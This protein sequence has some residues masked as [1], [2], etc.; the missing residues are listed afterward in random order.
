MSRQA[1][2]QDF[3]IPE[4]RGRDPQDYEVREDG[5]VARKDRWE[6]GIRRI[7]SALGDQRRE[8]EVEDVVSA[9]EALIA[10]MPDAPECC[11]AP[12]STTEKPAAAGE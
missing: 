4:F 2:M 9:V 12:D 8:F 6:N 10:N 7:R 11:A 5:K 3:I 1:T